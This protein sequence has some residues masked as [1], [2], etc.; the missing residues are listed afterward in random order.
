MLNQGVFCH[1]YACISIQ[2]RRPS[3]GENKLLQ[4]VGLCKALTMGSTEWNCILLPT[5]VDGCVNLD[6]QQARGRAAAT[7]KVQGHGVSC[8]HFMMSVE[9]IVP[10]DKMGLSIGIECQ[11]RNSGSKRKI[12]QVH[13]VT[14]LKCPT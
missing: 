3:L 13:P 14:G 6:A 1:V 8:A 5:W 2:Q 11:F 12:Q 7:C 4:I 10:R 9:G